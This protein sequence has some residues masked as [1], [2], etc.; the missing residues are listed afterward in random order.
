[1][2]SICATRLPRICHKVAAIET[3]PR[4]MAS[5]A[6]RG[7]RWGQS[8]SAGREVYYNRVPTN[9]S[10]NPAAIDHSANLTIVYRK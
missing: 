10:P 1:M 4:H 8:A 3:T 6:F 7:H 5:S 9:Q 2:Q